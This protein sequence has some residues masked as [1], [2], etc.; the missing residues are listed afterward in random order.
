MAVLILVG[1]SVSVVAHQHQKKKEAKERTI[2][3]ILGEATLI[4]Q[5]LATMRAVP[6]PPDVYAYL[7]RYLVKLGTQLKK[8]DAD[9]PFCQTLANAVTTAEKHTTPSEHIPFP[10]GISLQNIQRDLKVLQSF[11]QTKRQNSF[12][13]MQLS[14]WGTALNEL[15]LDIERE[16]FVRQCESHAQ[17]GRTRE[18]AQAIN[19]ALRLV[20]KAAH[21]DHETR[22]SETERLKA[23]KGALFAQKD[24]NA[25]PEPDAGSREN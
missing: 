14:A 7:H 19:Y 12:E 24:G 8:I 15:R 11:L 23:I 2:K 6:V 22:Q 5:L 18:A 25:D 9:N 21:L 10:P 1:I 3:F 16:Y 20:N 17:A 4:A 13:H